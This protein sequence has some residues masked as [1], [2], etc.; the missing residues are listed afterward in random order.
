M[1]WFNVD[2]G[3]AFHQKA[4]RAGNTAIGLWTRAGSWSAHQ[5]T[6]GFV[7]ADIVPSLGTVTQARKLVS[8][9]LWHEVEGGYQFH[10]WTADGRNPSREQVLERRRK[11]REKKANARSKRYPNGTNSASQQVDEDRPQGTPEGLPGGVPESVPEGVGSTT[12]LPS[13]PNKE[14]SL[15]ESGPRRRGT[16]LPENFSVTPEMVSWARVEAP[17]VDGRRATAA[18]I[19][20]FR[21]APGQKGVKRDWVATWRNW[22]RRDQSEIDRRRPSNG[23]GRRQSTTDR[24]VAQ[25]ELLKT[26]PNPDVLAAGGF[27]PPPMTPELLMLPGGAA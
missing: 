8:A 9:G 25:A 14:D 23:G 3:F 10:E 12:P 19:D 22:M 7:P 1:P 11:D 4:I 20:H 15:R 24:A 18:F 27:S 16:R 2:D 17:D 13:T 26:N 6:E 5:L 21:S